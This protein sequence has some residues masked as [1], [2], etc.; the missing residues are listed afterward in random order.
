MLL[1]RLEQRHREASPDMDS[2]GHRRGMLLIRLEGEL[3]FR[4]LVRPG[5]GGR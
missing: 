1:W 5:N 4:R 2:S 3:N